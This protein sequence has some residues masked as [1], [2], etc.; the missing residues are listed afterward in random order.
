MGSCL[1]VNEDAVLGG[2]KRRDG[3]V[4]RFEGGDREGLNTIKINSI[5]F[6][7]NSK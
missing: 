4:C 7:R 3:D 6:P 1:F 2:E 5:K